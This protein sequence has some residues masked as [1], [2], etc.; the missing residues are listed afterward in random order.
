VT[1][2]LKAGELLPGGLIT[3]TVELGN[4]NSWP[5]DPMGYGSYIT[6]T[7]PVGTTFVRAIPYW[8]P[9]N[10]WEPTSINGREITWYSDSWGPASSF[11]FDLVLQIDDTIEPGQGLLNLIEVW[12]NNPDD[13]DSNP[14]NNNPLR[15]NSRNHSAFSK[16]VSC[17]WESP[18]YPQAQV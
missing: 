12:S 14:A 16:L 4:L 9:Q 15:C 11:M 18:V 17:R 3:Y 7:I 13:I 10:T 5:F 1:K 6:D 2:W 8:D